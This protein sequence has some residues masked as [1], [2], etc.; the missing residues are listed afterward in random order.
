[1]ID[2]I[3]FTIP[4]GSFQLHFRWYGVL[5]VFGIMVGAWLAEKEIKRRG[6]NPD[7]IWDGLLWIL[8]AAIIGARLWYVLNDIFGGG[9]RFIDE[10]GRIIRITEGGL[11]IF[12]AIVFGLV[13]AY[14]FA[15]KNKIDILLMLDS[16]APS[17]LLGQA[18]ARPANFINQ[19][20]YGPPTDLP[21][22][23]SILGDNR[24]APWNNLDAFPEE[25]TRFH[26][27]F[28]YEMIWN[29]I[30]ASLILWLVRKYGDKAKPGTAFA[31]W[32]ILAG[33][34]RALIETFRPDQPRIPG[35]LLSYSRLIAIL[36]AVIGTIWLL[37]R[38]EILRLPFL[39]PGPETYRLPKKKNRKTKKST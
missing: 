38:Y 21:W 12:G 4:L 17:L 35:T 6:G 7:W 3:I 37:V 15:K 24:M 11:H 34:G 2:P 29:I 39:E 1:M 36:M 16:A 27:T 22:G 14:F 9:K 30:T 23:I 25:S 26:P 18:L 28:A 19:E 33:I 31:L 32:L 13:T 8:P 5:I 10:P 20:L